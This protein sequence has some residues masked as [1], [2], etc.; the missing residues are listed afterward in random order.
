MFVEI[1]SGLCSP[2]LTA[3]GLL[4]ERSHQAGR[5]WNIT[6]SILAA[7]EPFLLTHSND[8]MTLWDRRDG[9]AFQSISVG[10]EVFG[11]VAALSEVRTGQKQAAVS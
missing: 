8:V 3:L 1:L 11:G 7:S 9:S 5:R 6:G 10:G 4:Q 2:G